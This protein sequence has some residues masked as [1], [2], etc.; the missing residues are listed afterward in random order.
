MLNSSTVQKA[1]TKLDR[2]IMLSYEEQMDEIC[3]LAQ[4]PP[5]THLPIWT[6]MS[7]LTTNLI[8]LKPLPTSPNAFPILHHE[9]FLLLLASTFPINTHIS[10]TLHVAKMIPLH[11]IMS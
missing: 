6:L 7:S 2:S 3:R 9:A 10:H 1:Q 8:N 11:T 4:H 5:T